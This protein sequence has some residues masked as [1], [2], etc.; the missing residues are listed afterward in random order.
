MKLSKKVGNDVF[1]AQRLVFWEIEVKKK[2]GRRN[3]NE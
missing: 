1:N 2:G 3:S